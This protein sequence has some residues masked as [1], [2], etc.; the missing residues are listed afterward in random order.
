MTKAKKMAIPVVLALAIGAISFTA[1][2]AS[3]YSSPAEVAAAL[4][5]K[6][7]DEVTAQKSEDG[8]TYGSIADEAGKLEEFKTEMVALKKDI[9]DEKV[10]AGTM[11]QERADEILAAIEL[12]MA[13]CDGTGSGRTGE[14]MGAGFGFGK[15]NG[16]GMRNGQGNGQGM[17][18]GQG[19]GM[20]NCGGCTAATP[21]P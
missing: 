1:F 16:Q 8:T 20:G 17:R 5:G 3:S 10:A 13:N 7:V 21:N 19:G 4:T 2:A 15:G 14:G 9:L 18:N 11:T 12:N 6:S